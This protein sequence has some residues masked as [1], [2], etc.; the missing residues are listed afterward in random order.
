[1][2]NFFDNL[3][4]RSPNFIKEQLE[5]KGYDVIFEYT[6][7]FKDQNLLKEEYAVRINC[8][9]KSCHVI[10]SCFNTMI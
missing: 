7:G 1:M 8:K 9:E 5:K 3:I 4:G 6:K 2:S 10:L